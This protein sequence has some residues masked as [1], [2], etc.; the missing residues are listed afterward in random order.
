MVTRSYEVFLNPKF[1][2]RQASKKSIKPWYRHK[3]KK[4]KPVPLN[5]DPENACKGQIVTDSRNADDV[6][7]AVRERLSQWPEAGEMVALLMLLKTDQMT[8]SFLPSAVESTSCERMDGA[9]V[10]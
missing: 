4:K 8:A 10:R 5:V 7:V 6:T 3:A 9:D 2:S 1:Q